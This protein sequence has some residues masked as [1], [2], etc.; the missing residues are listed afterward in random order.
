MNIHNAL[1]ADV[2]NTHGSEEQKAKF[3]PAFV[4]G[5]HVGSFALSEPGTLRLMRKN[6]S[7][8]YLI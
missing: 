2:I 1:F 4:N 3:L 7:S 6:H 8:R 5:D